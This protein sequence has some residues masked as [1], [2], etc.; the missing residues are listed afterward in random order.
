MEEKVG[1]ALGQELAEVL[2]KRGKVGLKL[3][4]LEYTSPRDPGR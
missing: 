4:G 1:S 3:I 2:D